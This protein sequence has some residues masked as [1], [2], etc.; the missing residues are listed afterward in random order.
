MKKV[1]LLS[2]AGNF[3]CLIQAVNNGADAVY[4]SGKK[5][6][7]RKF[8]NNFENN[9]LI[10]AIKY[11]HLY[12]VKIYVTVNTIIYETELDEVLN[13]VEFLYENK[14]DAIIVQDL[15][16]INIIRKKFPN[17]EIHA[18][19]QAHNHNAEG[20]K[21]LKDLGVK[22]VVL[23]R[24]LSLDEIKNIDVNIEKEVFVH[25]ALCISYSGC[26]LFSAMNGNRS[27]NRGECVGSCRLPYKLYENDKEIKT[28][29]DYILSTK[30][31]CTLKNIDELI[32]A[33][34]TSFKIEGRMKSKEY[35]GYITKLYREKIDEYYRNKKIDVTDEEL[36]NIKKLYNRELTEGYLFNNY[37]KNLMNIKTSNHIGV[38][39]GK[40]LSVDSKKIK[41]S[42]TSELNQEDGI[43]F[44][45][46]K[47]MI[48]NMLYNSKGLLVNS[49]NKG[50]IAVLDNKI[51]LKE[52]KEVRKT[53]DIKLSNEINKI[54]NK[55]IKVKL[56]C[57][58][59]INKLLELTISDGTNIITE[60]SNIV[61]KATNCPT[62]IERIKT[63]LE[64]MG[65]TPFECKNIKI[66]MDD[67][68][69]VSIKELNELRRTIIEELKEKREYYTPHKI[70]KEE[71]E[72]KKIKNNENNELKINIL[73]RN[74]E[75]LKTCIEEKINNIYVQDYDLYKK[76]QDNSNVFYRTKRVQNN[77]LEFKNNNLLVT[78]LGAINKYY[79]NN[80]IVGDYFLNVINSET[81]KL[82]MNK[83]SLLTLSVE[84]SDDE[85]NELKEY[86][87]Y[88][89]LYVYG[90]VELMV[91]K[92]C[93][94]NMI[95]NNDD[96]KCDICMNNKKYYLVDQENNKYPILSEKHLTHIIHYKELDLL[97][98]ISKY[99]DYGYNNFRMDLYEETEQEIKNLLSVI[100][101]SYER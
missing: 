20:I 92:Y 17:M 46:D 43:R 1:E 45:N 2:P 95:I 10:E 93:P 64:K 32:D 29:G 14:T 12:G 76:Y 16:L 81:I 57:T 40:V 13:Y 73:V 24:E 75:Q 69:F 63:Q 52:A 37:G 27:G 61:E 99:K 51:G 26:C 65:G 67:N 54:E 39:I 7:A 5:F 70:V 101:Y 23:A 62:D 90:R 59:K 28:E 31:L 49:L 9:E 42:L 4:L 66:D 53:L 78:E 88:I 11:C 41:I 83:V 8:A 55:K 36:T 79:K 85:I 84:A 30:S 60:Y 74:E 34:V 89:E 98:N 68:I 47:G 86:S 100:R 48:V 21:F 18:S 25:G 71:Y 58:A 87:N 3:D 82:L 50:D 19:T 94:L 38:V 96:R 35:T 77:Y 6:G 91:S 72:N 44:D 56:M 80:N 15:G 97:E 22:R 33:G